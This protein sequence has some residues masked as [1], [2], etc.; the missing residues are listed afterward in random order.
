[1]SPARK[2]KTRKR[3][4]TPQENDITLLQCHRPSRTLSNY[5]VLPG[6]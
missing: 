2:D 1:M 4:K 5:N 6:G 3:Y